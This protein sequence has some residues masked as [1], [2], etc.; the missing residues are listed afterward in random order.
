MLQ[1]LHLH[2]VPITE[3]H[4]RV[5]SLAEHWTIVFTE[6]QLDT[7]GTDAPLDAPSPPHWLSLALSKSAR[8]YMALCMLSTKAES[9]LYTTGPAPPI[10]MYT[11]NY[12]M[13]LSPTHSTHSSMTQPE[14]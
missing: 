11:S 14:K 13:P 8:V 4:T 2:T 9:L 3:T 12:S 1:A 7:P 10:T 5:C 6:G